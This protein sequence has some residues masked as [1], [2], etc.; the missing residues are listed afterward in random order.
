ML[1]LCSCGS[2]VLAVIVITGC[3]AATKSKGKV[4]G[5]VS[6]DGKPMPDGEISFVVMGEPPETL[7]VKEGKFSGE[8]THGEKRVEIRA[9]REGKIPPTATIK[10]APKEN[11]IA[12]KY[13]SASTLKATVSGSGVQPSKFEV[14]AE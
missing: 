5:E 1:K 7:A 9:Y 11:Y 8:V 13:N 10:E 4:S 6:L 3:G 12:A 2:L 14:K